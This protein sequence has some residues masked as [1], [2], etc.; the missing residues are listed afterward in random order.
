MPEA[1]TRERIL[2]AC[3]HEIAASGVRGLR[4]ENVAKRARVSVGLVYYHFKDRSGLLNATISAV[5]DAAQAR[6]PVIDPA[7]DS[8]EIVERMLAAEFG[9]DALTRDDSVVWNEIRAI[10]VF[11]ADLQRALSST[12]SEWESQVG[13]QVAAAG[14]PHA[15]VADTATLLTS[16]VE[17]LSSRW[18]TDQIDTA[19][20][21]RLI[22]AG[23]AA[24]L[25]GARTQAG[26]S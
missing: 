2:A 10:A 6:V 17:G 4:V 22:R 13:E 24:I 3:R 12:T 15:A 5:N 26:R 18:L 7:S 11:E 20:A 19:S 23:A 14:I 25:A 9:D 8:S 21:L 16:L 1:D